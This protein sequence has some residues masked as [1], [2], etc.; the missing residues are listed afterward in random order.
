MLQTGAVI[1]SRMESSA[2][3]APQGWNGRAAA[4]K[5]KLQSLGFAGVLAYGILNTLYYTAAFYTI[6]V[7]VA[8][9]PRGM[10]QISTERQ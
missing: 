5:S 7:Y 8:K 6:W 4:M 2:P 3:P 10:L 1:F 9:V